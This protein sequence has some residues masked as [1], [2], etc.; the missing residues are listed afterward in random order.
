M[1]TQVPDVPNAVELPMGSTEDRDLTHAFQRGEDGAYQEIYDRYGAR[2]QRVCRRMLL[3]H[4]DAQEASQETFLRVYQGLARFNGRYQLGP[5]ITR[6]ATNVCLDQ[7]RSRGRHPEDFTLDLAD[8]QPTN[9]DE[10]PEAVVLRNAEGRRVKRV[11]DSLPPLHRAAIVLRDFEGLSYCDVAGVMGITEP[12][13][14]ALLHRARKGFRRTWPSTIAALLPLRLI[15]RF[16]GIESTRDQAA[17]AVTQVSASGSQLVNSCAALF[18]QCGAIASERLGALALATMTTTAVVAGPTLATSSPQPTHQ[19]SESVLQVAR[20][21][22]DDGPS[23]T[24]PAQRT[25]E[26]PRTPEEAPS[27]VP[28]PAPTGEPAPEE[29]TGETPNEGT[30]DGTDPPAS[31]GRVDPTPAPTTAPDQGFKASVGFDRGYPIPSAKPTL[32]QA[33]VDCDSH[34]FEQTMTVPVSNGRET[35]EGRLRLWMGSTLSMELF[36]SKNGTE[37]GYVGGASYTSDSRSGDTLSVTFAGTY[38]S[39][40]SSA[41]ALGLPQSGRFTASLNLDCASRSVISETLVLNI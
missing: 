33:I 26:A 27:A 17:Q 14:K 28:T 41:T 13:L 37:A 39:E 20:E 6:I 1:S 35:L 18:Q 38:G 19:A 4:H 40:G 36:V 32:H 29:P 16:R 31:P 22:K 9:G 21:M 5:W 34:S 23:G 11:L 15:R 30:T 24:A 8:S 7:L 25:Q 3:N 10:E 2:V 12:Q